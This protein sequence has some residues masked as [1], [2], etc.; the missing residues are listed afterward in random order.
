[1]VGPLTALSVSSLELE[2][3]SW[4]FVLK[5]STNNL[6]Y[7]GPEHTMPI[8]TELSDCQRERLFA[9]LDLHRE[10]KTNAL[11]KI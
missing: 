10:Q 8:N 5:L 2:L 4:G 11:S 3:K 1:M 9:P 7:D 6:H